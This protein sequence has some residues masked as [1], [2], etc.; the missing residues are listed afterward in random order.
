MGLSTEPRLVVRKA[1]PSLFILCL[2]HPEAKIQQTLSSYCTSE[3]RSPPFEQD[4]KC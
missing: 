3:P 4:P 1:R 2:G